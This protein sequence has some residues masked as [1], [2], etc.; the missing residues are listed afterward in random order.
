MARAM[1]RHAVKD[2]PETPSGRHD[3]RR[4][5][6]ASA[7][8][9][10]ILLLL[11]L[12]LA[13]AASAKEAIAYFGTERGSGTL[14]GQFNI[15]GDIAVNSTGAGPADRGDIYVL[16]EGNGRIQRF[17]QDENGTPTNP[18]DDSYPFISAWGADV[19]GTASG[20]SNYEICTAAASCKA[21]LS[22]GGNG[23]AAGNGVADRP[24]SVAVDQDSGNIY[25]ADSDNSRV[26]VYT[27]DGTFLR[28]FG[29]D[30]VQAGPGEG[31]IGFE[32][33]VAA[34]GD[35]CKAGV[36]GAGV[37][38]INAANFQRPT[39]AISPADGNPATG[40][41]FLADPGN[42]RV[43]TYDLDGGGPASFGSATNFTS[44]SL[45]G[46]AV[47]SRGVVYV[48]DGGAEIDRYDSKGVNGGGVGFLPSIGVPPVRPMF[49]NGIVALEA[50]PDSDG[51]GPDADSI[52]ALYGSPGG[53]SIIQQFGPLN[54]PG[55]SAPPVAA[56]AIHGEGAEFNFLVGLGL[57]SSTGRLFVATQYPRGPNYL[58]PEANHGVY[59]LD[60]AGGIPSASLDSISSVT[61]TSAEIQ[62]TVNPN[63]PPDVA[64]QLEYSTDGIGWQQ[65]PQVVLG[66]QETPQSL[67]IPLNPP[68]GGLEPSTFYHV[69]L[70]VTK[71][72]TPSVITAEKTFTTVAAGPAAETIGSP[73]RTMTTA[74]LE[75]RVNPRKTATTYHF[76]YGDAGPCSTNA[77][78][79]TPIRAAG[80]GGTFQPISEQV[81]DLE[82][83]TTYHYRL[84]AEN[85]VG[86]PAIGEDM[87]VST[88]AD[89]DPL[90]HGRFPGPP[91]SDRAF[92]LVSLPNSGGNPVGPLNLRFADTGNRALYSI[93]GGTPISDTGS[94]YGFY[95]A[96]RTASGW[97]TRSV[98]PPRS[99]LVGSAWSEGHGPSDLSSFTLWNSDAVAGVAT[100]WR[101]SATGLPSRV[102]DLSP[103]R[104]RS[105]RS[106]RLA[107]TESPRVIA[108]LSGGG[109][110]PAHPTDPTKEN[111][112]DVT[113]GSPELAS[114]LP[115]G[116]IPKCGIAEETTM[117]L[118]DDGS[119]LFF[120]S[121]DSSCSDTVRFYMRDLE[122]GETKPIT[123]TPISGGDCGSRYLMRLTEEAAYFWTQSRLD[124]TDTAPAACSRANAPDFAISP[125]GDIY[126]YT[127]ADGSLK[128]LTC[129]IPGLDADVVGGQNV[130]PAVVAADGSRIYFRSVS[131]TP[132]VTGASTASGTTYRLNTQSGEL[133]WLGAGIS[134]EHNSRLVSPDGAVAVFSSAS[135]SLN[136][137]GGLDNGGKPQFYRYDDRDRSLV[138]VS[139]PQDGS[140][141]AA[142]APQSS[143]SDGSA[144]GKIV[145][146][147]T[148]LPLVSKDQNT[149][150][151]GEEPTVGTDVY[152]WRDGRLF[153]ISDGLTS[154][155]RFTEPRVRDVSPSGRD[156][157][158][159]A[160]A[161]YTADALDGYLRLYDARIGGG[162]E[163]PRPP[164]PC[165]LEVCQGTPRGAPEEQA[166]GTGSFAG[167]GNVAKPRQK[168]ARC[169]AGKRKVRRNGKTR[170]LKPKSKKHAKARANDHRRTGR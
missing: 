55:L 17:A 39:I 73:L 139:C 168:K 128:C 105:E 67:E 83:N 113:S 116:S 131:Q 154:W 133:R 23:T 2:S 74:R 70:R 42:R 62:A 164:K 38:Q 49:S 66:S 72:F 47:D 15:P 31:G 75:G 166:S 45:L 24:T 125:D 117:G 78:T 121:I 52:Y 161:Q 134:I 149:A 156:L 123:G 98:S 93:L 167:P 89:E 150:G 92:E 19:D 9:A 27:G 99:E 29:W 33:C 112:Y 157:F 130:A 115:D 11:L 71:A 79:A 147:G 132:L 96:E 94:L 142:S 1:E 104:Q 58:G 63:G 41:V 151:P 124:P 101:L 44:L 76:E 12:L 108:G 21:A 86:S 8:I 43:D 65:L 84:V 135:P 144:D 53:E 35:V 111:L 4:I 91:G 97:Q 82:P 34:N 141:A 50:D 163:F 165:P 143:D 3:R 61:A 48:A 77:C 148:P 36:P 16:D 120:F 37:G 100:A 107:A 102:F 5:G 160:P 137:A 10:S 60:E 14:G 118:S 64:Y 153:L 129:V 170:C 81:D 56:D 90:S 146:F 109:L 22:S 26:N 57:D 25:V 126:R 95:F 127:I 103:P 6:L 155:P 158:F 18:Y 46:V 40:S 88:R 159:S 32:I 140:P 162:F 28:S 85:G 54:P 122:K 30:V 80:S 20:G 152:E 69:R 7:A 114:L 136:P 119:K 145:A 110:D 59:V 106:P 87:T 51:A 138:C 68:P 169:A 13:P